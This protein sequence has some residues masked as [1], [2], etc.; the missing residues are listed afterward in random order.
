MPATVDMLRTRVKPSASPGRATSTSHLPREHE[1]GLRTA[2]LDVA[3]LHS[4]LPASETTATAAACP[5]AALAGRHLPRIAVRA[6]AAEFFLH[7][8][9]LR[10]HRSRILPRYLRAVVHPRQRRH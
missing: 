6:A 5:P 1:R 10:Q 7:R 9:I 4:A 8:R 3:D 2:F